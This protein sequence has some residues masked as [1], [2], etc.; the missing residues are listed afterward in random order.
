[1]SLPKRMKASEPS[2]DDLASQLEFEEDKLD[3]EEVNSLVTSLHTISE[4]DTGSERV[5]LSSRHGD[6][7]IKTHQYR[8]DS[9]GKLCRSK[10]V[11]SSRSRPK[12]FSVDCRPIGVAA[13]LSE[14]EY[15]YHY[16]LAER[17]SVNI[18]WYSYRCRALMGS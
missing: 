9:S 16:F 8:Y 15:S 13:I 1:M 14:G 3:K 2:L 5:L 17:G 4:A 7:G 6:D 11:R 18:I 12:S 10:R